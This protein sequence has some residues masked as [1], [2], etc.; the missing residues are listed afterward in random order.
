MWRS[1]PTG[2]CCA[3]KNKQSLCSE[4]MERV[5]GEWMRAFV[6]LY[7]I[8]RESYYPT[9]PHIVAYY[10]AVLQKAIVVT[11]TAKL[12]FFYGFRPSN[13]VLKK[14]SQGITLSHIKFISNARFN[15]IS[16][17]RLG[18]PSD[19]SASCFRTIILHACVISRCVVRLLVIYVP[20][21]HHHDTL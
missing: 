9:S 21:F 14:L 19:L 6:I 3:R 5:E 8:R 10:R 7:G 13:T 16:N 1:W 12:P 17:R 18:L 2:G 20:R 15:I 11:L 4:N